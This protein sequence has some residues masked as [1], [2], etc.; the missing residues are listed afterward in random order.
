MACL[1]GKC[2]C[3]VTEIFVTVLFSIVRP[4]VSKLTTRFQMDAERFGSV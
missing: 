2:Y 3:E 4:G 1:F